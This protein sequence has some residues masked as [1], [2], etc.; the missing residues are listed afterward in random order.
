MSDFPNTAPS[1]YP[2]FYRTY[3][4]NQNGYRESWEQVCD[5]NIYS[6]ISGLKKVGKL[7]SEETKL[8]HRMQREAK[9]FPS[10]RWLWVGGTEWYANPVNRHGAYNCLQG[11]TEVITKEFGCQSISTLAGKQVHVLN[12]Q[13]AWSLVS[14]KSYGIQPVYEMMLKRGHYAKTVKCTGNHDWI[15]TSGNR[16]ATQELLVGTHLQ[17]LAPSRPI[18]DEAYALGVQHGIV[19]GDG[20][21]LGTGK[22]S[23]LINFKVRLCGKK[24]ELLE[25]FGNC[26]RSYPPSCKGD[27]V[28]Y[29]NH[30]PFVDYVENGNLKE[31]PFSSNMSYVLGFVH[32]L[33]ATDGSVTRPESPT[34]AINGTE[35]TVEYIETVCPSLGMMVN[36]IRRLYKKGDSSNF[37]TRGTNLYELSFYSRSI[38]GSDLLRTS[39]AEVF[40]QLKPSAQQDW[41]V[42][43]IQDLGYSEEVYCCEEPFTHSFVLNDGLLTGNCTTTTVDSP[44]AFGYM[45]NLAMM[46]CGTGANLESKHIGKLPKVS[47]KLNVSVIGSFSSGGSPD[48]EIKKNKDRH[49][50]IVGDS[51]KGWVDA[52]QYLIDL[53]FDST[54]K[55]DAIEV[56]VDI[57]NVRPSGEKLKSFGG[58]ANPV[59]I[60]NLFPRVGE[61]LNGALGRQLKADECCLLIDEAALV[62]V[63][64]SIRRSAGMRQ[65][66]HDAPLLK[67]NLWQQDSEGNWSIDPKRDA[68][69]MANHTRVFHHKPTLEE[70]VESVRSQYYSGEGAI[71]YA[72]EAERR[73][74]G[75]GRYE[76]NPCGEIIGSNLHC[77]LAEIHV[78][79]LDPLNLEDQ[80]NA[81]KAGAIAVCSLLHENFVINRYAESRDEDPIVAVCP[82]GIFDFFVN[83][84]GSEWLKWWEDG[85]PDTIQGLEFKAKEQECLSRWKNIVYEAV[86]DYCDRHDLK[87]PNRYTAVQPSGTKSLLTGASSGWHPP[88]AQRFIRRITF[89]RDEPVALACIDYGYNVV[90]GQDDKDENG[91]LLNDIY[92]PRCS[93]WLVEIPTEVDWANLPGVDGIHIEQFSALAQY[94]FYMQVQRYYTGHN[95]SSTIELR[96]DEI[97][98]LGERIYRSI[99]E[100]EGY[101]SSALLAR[102]D[103]LETFPRLPFEPISKDEYQKQMA[104]VLERRVSDDFHGLLAKYD[105][106]EDDEAGPAACDSA[107]CLIG[108]SK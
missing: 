80:E 21:I 60:P 86:K 102:F 89:R 36:N 76:L 65:F 100:D 48:T 40:S 59:K 19:Y 72:P 44:E 7:T 51:R 37:G 16:L 55:Y 4:R 30:S 91:K 64:G 41:R 105:K 35:D 3:S 68:L 107:Q 73:A 2:V 97:E 34:V 56:V 20:S 66:D 23:D 101:I 57:S 5:R 28:V 54:V 39:H 29:V 50:L 9:T 70:C 82:T 6:P 26:K 67:T 25:F 63:A 27:P 74:G 15:T 1:A 12:A 33:I 95:T 47:T 14:F 75:K 104:G 98:I 81:F 71:Q 108:G 31:L 78:N 85:R 94:D 58:T 83:M 92:D 49:F 32:G 42:V 17:Y 62:V 43:D 10:G 22:P 106:G 11:D 53:A 93:T 8:V 90:P 77:N 18:L 24:Q 38:F 84:F 52:Y 87:C 61:I 45:M 88:K 103:S 46:G 96:E 69:R 79:Q 99:Q 13:E